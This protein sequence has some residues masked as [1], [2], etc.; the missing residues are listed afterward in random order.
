MGALQPVLVAL[1]VAG[2]AAP[3]GARAAN[4]ARVAAG[5]RSAWQRPGLQRPQ[6]IRI[7][8]RAE[9]LKLD[10]RRDYILRC[11]RR[12]LDLPWTLTVWGG[13]NVVMDGCDL[14]LIHNWVARFTDQAGTLWLRDVHFGGAR[15]TGGIQ[16]Q[17]PQATV[18]M[19][20]VLFDTV[21]GGPH[22]D[23]AELVQSWSGPRRLLIDG[24]SGSTTYQ[25]LFLEPNQFT[26]VGPRVFDLRHIS[27]DDS[28]GGY[29]LWLGDL[30]HPMATWHLSDVYVRPP[31]G[32]SWLGWWSWP[33]PVH[34]RSPWSGART[35]TP[36]SGTYVRRVPGGLTGVDQTAVPVILSG[37]LCHQPGARR[38]PPHP[39]A[40]IG[41]TGVRRDDR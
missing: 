1:L 36:P 28:R 17:E 33:Q 8:A 35:G 26:G 41:E 12:S 31:A 37:E 32:R 4:A 15:L 2:P 13:H 6:T 34:G 24:L 10:P 16:L 14:H 9:N 5:R 27:I 11:P 3:A 18:V 39:H 29:A 20:D 22:T 25:G 7:G 40:V 21:Y 23:H 38:S 30:L 19:R